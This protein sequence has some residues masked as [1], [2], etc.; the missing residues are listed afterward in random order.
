M[1]DAT[2]PSEEPVETTHVLDLGAGEGYVGEALASRS[3]R[4]KVQLCD[5]ANLNRTGLP[6]DT[7][8]GETLPYADAVFD[9]V[10][11]YFVLHHCEHPERVLSESFRVASQRVIIIESVVT[12]F[13]QNQLLRAADIA[14]NRIR[15]GG[16]LDA[17]EQY[18][19][20][21]STATWVQAVEEQGGQIQDVTTWPGL[22]HP[23]ARIVAKPCAVV[24][25]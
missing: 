2:F 6:H 24:R 16:S 9:V 15:S 18:L 22:I 21:R 7:Y 11:L 14:A 12:G 13:V 17:Q 20:F 23:Q 19:D 3:A 4:L 1:T 8:A 25:D 5:I 10:I